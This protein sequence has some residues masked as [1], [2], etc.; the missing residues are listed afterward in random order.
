[1]EPLVPFR[2]VLAQKLLPAE[3]RIA[4]TLRSAALHSAA[5]CCPQRGGVG[6][7][8]WAERHPECLLLSAQDY[9]EDLV[10]ITEEKRSIIP[11]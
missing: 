11:M 5:L 1:M 7:S 9:N 2:P 8:F 10:C 6:R 4:G 3:H